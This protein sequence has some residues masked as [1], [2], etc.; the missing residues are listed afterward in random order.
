M[1]ASITSNSLWLISLNLSG[2]LFRSAWFIQPRWPSGDPNLSRPW[3]QS[4]SIPNSN[5]CVSVSKYNFDQLLIWYNNS[6]GSAYGI[7]ILRIYCTPR[8]IGLSASSAWVWLWYSHHS[9]CSL[10]IWHCLYKLPWMVRS[11][12]NLHAVWPRIHI[13]IIPSHPVCITSKYEG[14]MVLI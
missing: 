2:H 5:V 10:I 9:M 8:A 1:H 3:S 4:H 13:L 6:S 12:Q 11:T 14:D 7:W